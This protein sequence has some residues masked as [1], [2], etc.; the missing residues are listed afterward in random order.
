MK[1]TP[2]YTQ[3]WRTQNGVFKSSLQATTLKTS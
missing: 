2:D 3:F 1:P